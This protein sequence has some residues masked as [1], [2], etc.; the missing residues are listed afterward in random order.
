MSSAGAAGALGRKPAAGTLRLRLPFY[1]GGLDPHSLDDPLAALFAPAIADP[2]F[3]LDSDGRPY[4]AL[5]S[6]LPERVANGVRLS[7]RSELVS[8]RGKAITARDLVFSFKR[9]QALGGAAVL[10]AFRAPSLE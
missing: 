4:P 3:G 2:L 9:A 6:K 7:L 8:A 5:A 10:G 1:F